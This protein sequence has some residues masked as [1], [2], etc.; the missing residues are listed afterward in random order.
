[1]EIHTLISVAALG[2]FALACLASCL[3]WLAASQVARPSVNRLFSFV[4]SLLAYNHATAVSQETS[5]GGQSVAG[6]GTPEM[7]PGVAEAQSYGSTDMRSRTENSGLPVRYLSNRNSHSL[8]RLLPWD[9]TGRLHETDNGFRFVGNSVRGESVEVSFPSDQIEINYQKGNLLW[10]G[11][12]SWC[13]I[14]VEGE[15]HYFTSGP[16]K[17]SDRTSPK[18]ELSATAIYQS[19]TNRYIRT[20]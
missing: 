13:V 7:E 16:Q 9:A 19:L 12:L 2:F 17:N 8:L 6:G 4:A 14:E 3:R 5:S 20:N 15:K 18:E 10:D 11:G 1:M